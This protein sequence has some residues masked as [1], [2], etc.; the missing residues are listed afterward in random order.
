M[1]IKRNSI[2]NARDF[3]AL[4]ETFKQRPCLGDCCYQSRPP[5][6]LSAKL[7]VPSMSRREM[8]E[9]ILVI[10]TIFHLQNE[11]IDTEKNIGT[12]SETAACNNEQVHITYGSPVLNSIDELSFQ[13]F[14]R[15]ELKKRDKEERTSSF[16]HVLS[17]EV[18]K[19]LTTRTIS[20]LLKEGKSNILDIGCS[21][22]GWLL[23]MADEF[24]NSVFVG[25]D[26]KAAEFPKD[27][28][29]NVAFIECNVLDQI[30]F[31]ENTFDYVHQSGML[32]S[33]KAN[34][35]RVV[36]RD[37]VRVLKPGGYVEISELD[38]RYNKA[39]PVT[40]KIHRA[41]QQYIESKGQ[42]CS[43]TP[44][45]EGFSR[46]ISEM[47]SE[48]QEVAIGS[49][50]GNIGETMLQNHLKVYR[51][52]T[53]AQNLASILEMTELEYINHVNRMPNEFF[54]YRTTCPY[55]RVLA[56]KVSSNN[57]SM[58]LSSSNNFHSQNGNM[59]LDGRIATI[60]IINGHNNEKHSFT[61]E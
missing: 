29:P 47:K 1:I 12:K 30:P 39:G 13:L 7:M 5:L 32:P 57:R 6:L 2:S 11:R 18:W 20:N 14:Q 35:W 19:S 15:D 28:P 48:Q 26:I 53:I 51:D 61:E 31:P 42:S 27:S 55:F 10:N 25:L 60:R 41:Y 54:H 3:E 45:L 58:A 8:S 16:Y 4:T 34:E 17:K 21:S 52:R 36:L 23:D 38:F 56:K 50:G 33:Y 40:K 46:E 44:Y 9:D 49:W 24:K 43:V 59:D 22:G 37:I